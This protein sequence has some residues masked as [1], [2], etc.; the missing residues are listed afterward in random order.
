[1]ELSFAGPSL[2]STRREALRHPASRQLGL[3]PGE[4]RTEASLKGLR[5]LDRS[6]MVSGPCEARLYIGVRNLSWKRRAARISAPVWTAH[7]RLLH[8]LLSSQLRPSAATSD[9]GAGFVGSSGTR[10]LVGNR[11]PG[12]QNDSEPKTSRAL[13]R[14][15]SLRDIMMS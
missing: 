13:V 2:E 5:S 6:H 15:H 1:M 8:Q 14:L 11:R 10:N 9:F 7:S 3:G 4:I 12:L